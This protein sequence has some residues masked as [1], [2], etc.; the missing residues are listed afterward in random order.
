MLAFLDRAAAAEAANLAARRAAEQAMA[1]RNR[2]IAEQRARSAAAATIVDAEVPGGP[3]AI[4]RAAAEL[5]EVDRP[6]P[7]QRAVETLAPG[8]AR[9]RGM[10]TLLDCK[11]G[12]TISLLVDGRN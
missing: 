8:N 7:V 2:A 6:V 4:R 9:I 3:P 1:E 12:V 11:D 10:L 5:V